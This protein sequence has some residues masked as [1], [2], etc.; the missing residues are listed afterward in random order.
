MGISTLFQRARDAVAEVEKE[1]AKLIRRQGELQA[2]RDELRR[3]PPSREDCIARVQA[4]VRVEVGALD[5]HL[6]AHLT[7]QPDRPREPYE[8]RVTVGPDFEV[9]H[10]VSG[11]AFRLSRGN[12]EAGR[13]RMASA[14]MAEALGARLCHLL[15]E[16]PGDLFGPPA[17]RTA[18][19]IERCEGELRAVA[20]ALAAL[21]G[22]EIEDEAN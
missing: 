4:A 7:G 2:K 20:R 18:R 6:R 13:A 8:P 12:P 14:L 16:L 15:G 5:E 1:R 21:D 9:Q 3:R 17:E 19:E 22:D 11:L 10:F